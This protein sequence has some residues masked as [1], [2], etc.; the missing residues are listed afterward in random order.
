[1]ARY[2][3]ELS[4]RALLLSFAA[5]SALSWGQ[6]YAQC[7][8]APVTTTLTVSADCNYEGTL[9]LGTGANVTISSGVILWNDAGNGRSGDPVAIAIGTTSSSFTNHGGLYTDSQW[10]LTVNGRLD[11]LVNTGAIESGYRRAV[12]VQPGHSI[13]TLTNT[14]LLRGPFADI[15]NA[16][17]I[18]T[19]NN[20]QGAATNDAVT[21]SGALPTTYNIIIDS[22][23]E[24]GQLARVD[25]VTGSMQF[26]I[27][28]TSTVAAGTYVSVLNGLTLGNLT[29]ALT[30]NYGGFNWTLGLASG[31]TSI[32]DLVFTAVPSAM[33]A[34]TVYALADIPGSVAPVFDGGR[35]ALLAGD[36]SAQAFTLNAGGGTLTTAAGGTA[37][38]T[39]V[40]SGTGALTIDGTGTLALSGANT[41]G[42]GTT[43]SSGTLDI[44]GPSA[45]GTGPVF[46]AFGSSL[47]GTGTVN[48][49]ITVAGT[50]KP[51][52]SPGFL[53][54]NGNVTMTGGSTYQQDIAGNVQASAATPAGVSGFYSF[55]QITGGQF[56]IQPNATLVPRL[57]ALFTPGEPG[58]GSAVY[59]PVLGDRFRIVTADG[60]ISGEFSTLTQ[61]AELAAGTQLIQL[62]NIGGSN[63]LDLAVIPTSYASTLAASHLN[64][65]ARS[66]GNALDRIVAAS[67]AGTS[68]A[69]QDQLLRATA[70]QTAATLPNFTRGLAGEVY[71]AT[72]SVV[73]QATRRMQQS[74][75]SHL[76]RDAAS[77]DGMNTFAQRERGAWGEV[78]YQRG[79]RSNDS[80]ASSFTSD[81]SQ[82][83]VGIDAYATDGIKAG[84]GIALSNTDVD[85][86]RGTG[87]VR[88]GALFVYAGVPQ[89]A[90]LLDATAS[91]GVHSSEHSRSDV[92]GFTTGL[93]A[94]THGRDAMVSA[95]VSQSIDMASTRIAPYAR[96]SWQQVRQSALS[97]GASA[98]ALAV[99]RF[100][101]DGLRA[102]IGMNLGS[103]NANPLKDA[104]TW[105]FNLGVGADSSKLISPTLNASL[106]GVQTSIRTPDAGTGFVQ[107]GFFG[108]ARFAN[109]AFAYVGVSGEARRG[110]V[111][112]G[113]NAG[114]RLTF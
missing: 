107:A 88:Q 45:L 74:V 87:K 92:T 113:L 62:Y 110:A 61:P 12:V 81:L 39:G 72:L 4:K 71:A 57:S 20:L 10:G 69:A 16:G 97:E 23:T 3:K 102:V 22:P 14:G 52:H 100:N 21:Y 103:I 64:A 93:N 37:R 34:G 82:L 86:E 91:L 73:P 13:G 24:Y 28:N 79:R 109:N 9:T 96:L 94:R 111:L 6:A 41:Y 99:E 55:L 40:F 60:G 75:A 56:V 63:S 30:G 54:V 18:Q 32:W 26:G 90:W 17:T 43:V 98:S 46:I 114:V 105:R 84:G 106:A 49:P 51:G 77:A 11:S 47:H 31:S 15:T 8:G 68:T 38:L 42:G 27:Y 101:E 44:S 53:A 29:G 104:Q 19:F 70:A 59:T 85:A 58:F 108:T 112:G 66:A 33:T 2:Q 5:L 80:N 89:G 95:G 76:S 35:V 7:G 25:T 83:V 78:A 48:G 65:N 36:I 1:M 50:L 67:Q